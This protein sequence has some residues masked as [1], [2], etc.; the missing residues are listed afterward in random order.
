[1]GALPDRFLA[2]A[3]IT[4]SPSGSNGDGRKADSNWSRYVFEVAS[5]GRG[6]LGK[7]VLLIIWVE[8]C[9]EVSAREVVDLAAR[10]RESGGARL[11][12][13]VAEVEAEAE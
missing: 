6:T 11:V 7:T 13:G 5:L 3:L 8:W 12:D 10:L 2:M 1:M 4:P 9:E